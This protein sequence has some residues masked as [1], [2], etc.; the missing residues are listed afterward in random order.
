MP[1]LTGAWIRKPAAASP[2]IGADLINRS[3]MPQGCGIGRA[4]VPRSR[5]RSETL[6]Q[7][8]ARGSKSCEY[9][10]CKHFNNSSLRPRNLGICY[11]PAEP[12]W[13]LNSSV[14]KWHKRTRKAA[15][16]CHFLADNA[17]VAEVNLDGESGETG[18][19]K[20]DIGIVS[21][22]G[23]WLAQRYDASNHRGGCRH[24]RA[25]RRPIAG[26]VSF[27]PIESHPFPSIWRVKIPSATF[28][29]TCLSTLDFIQ[30]WRDRGRR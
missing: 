30:S 24:P 20:A 25:M 14:V 4:F 29:R 13:G 18:E 19:R 2:S 27:L 12:R 5:R 11:A 6:V 3:N 9:N 16:L 22:T 1:C 23:S 26:C 28:V 15:T 8:P 7:R 17:S 21:E 10:H